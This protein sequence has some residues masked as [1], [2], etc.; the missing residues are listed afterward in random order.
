MLANV[1]LRIS[2]ENHDYTMNRIIFMKN[3]RK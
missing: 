3:K 1:F 2:P